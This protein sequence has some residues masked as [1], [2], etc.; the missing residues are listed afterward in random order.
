MKSSK[1]ITEIIKLFIERET[2]PE[3]AM[4][5]LDNQGC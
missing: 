3:R 5:T 2:A 4:Q 1:L